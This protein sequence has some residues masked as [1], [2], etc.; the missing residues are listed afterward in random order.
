MESST[1][2]LSGGPPYGR[3]RFQGDREA[4]V[5]GRGSEVELP[6]RTAG[7]RSKGFPKRPDQNVEVDRG[8]VGIVVPSLPVGFDALP[9]T[10]CHLTV[11]ARH[12]QQATSLMLSP[13]H[14]R[15]RGTPPAHRDDIDTLHSLRQ[16]RA[17]A[18]GEIQNGVVYICCQV[19]EKW[20]HARPDLSAQP[21]PLQEFAGN[22]ARTLW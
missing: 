4:I 3:V 11:L 13:F 9:L 5:R 19:K 14:P 15:Y 6:H 8:R 10:E 22:L 7:L 2:F 21:A 18:C 17:P 12:N 20:P 1:L 16:R